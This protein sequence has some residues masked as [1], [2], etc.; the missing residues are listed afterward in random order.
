MATVP[1]RNRVGPI[2]AVIIVL[3][4]LAIVAPIV[5]KMHTDPVTWVTEIMNANQPNKPNIE[6][7]HPVW[8][9]M[10]SGLYYCR[11]SKFYGRMRPGFPMRQGNALQKGYRPAEGNVCP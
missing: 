10:R 5:A 3:A 11:Q 2:I 8:V 9:N 4:L 7:K 1:S 6:L